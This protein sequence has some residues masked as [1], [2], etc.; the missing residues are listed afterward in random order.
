MLFCNKLN[1]TKNIESILTEELG[2]NP[3]SD[4]LKA[5]KL[6]ERF[7]L[8]PN[9]QEGFILQGYAGT[10]KTSLIGA[11]VKSLVKIKMK[12]VLLAP[13]GR[14]AK[15]LASYSKKEAFT[16]HK[17][18]Y[19]QEEFGGATQ[20]VLGKNLHTNTLFI[21]D[22]ASMVNSDAGIDQGFG[23]RDLLSDLISY[24]YN[25]KNCQLIFVGDYAQL[26]PVGLAVSP[27]LNADFLEHNYYIPFLSVELKEVVRQE[28]ESGIL[29]NATQFR[30]QIEKDKG[31]DLTINPDF[32]DTHRITGMELQDELESCVGKYGIEGTMVVCRSNKRANLFNQQIRNRILWFEDELCAGDLLM[33]VKN[34][35]FW[36]D[37][38]SKMG[39]IANG[40]I[41]E[42]LR[43]NRYEE[44]Y[45][46]R[47][48]DVSLRFV[49][50]S[51]EPEF[52]CKILMETID[53]E[54]PNLPR[55]RMKELFHSIEEDFMDVKSRHKRIDLIMKTPHM[56]A[57][58]VKFAYAVTCHKAQGGQW[59]AVFIDQGYLTDEMLDKEY[60]RWLYTAV[61][62]ATDKLYFVNFNKTF[63][64][65]NEEYF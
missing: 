42:I 59:P 56:N 17:K 57:L 20:F 1:K 47:F 18:I 16:I 39:F 29:F 26:P 21:V 43:V 45:G 28:K 48:A 3:T 38:K 6:L 15:V 60:M 52:D 54:G 44:L 34:N 27:A 40:D 7:I 11:L 55:N 8:E 35:Y 4:Q 23:K 22:E 24:V 30:R 31:Y 65:E 33:I 62:R 37:E 12:S 46:F 9:S 51:T 19:F 58:Q 13:T 10:G 50:N 25:G 49:D 53:V 5:I 32:P 14:A 36:I 61:T 63:F 2:Y 64:N 41:V